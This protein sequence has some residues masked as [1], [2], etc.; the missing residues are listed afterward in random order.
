MK[1]YN[2]LGFFAVGALLMS[3]CAVNDPLMDKMEAGQVVPTVSWELASSVCKAGDNAAFLGKY[4]TTVEGLNID[5]A[6]VWGRVF[7][8]ENA[9]ASQK[10]IPSP[11]YSK[12]INNS[13]EIRGYHLLKEF[14]HK[15][16]YLIGKEYHMNESFPTS[17]T[18]SPVNWSSPAEWDE[19]MFNAYFPEG[20]RD[21]FKKQMVD[22]LTIDSTY[23]SSL[24]Q[25]YIDYGF[26]KEQLDSINSH[27]PDLE[28]I[29]YSSKAQTEKKNE[30]NVMA[31]NWLWF[32]ID[33][34]D[35]VGYYYII[36]DENGNEVEIQIPTKE[37]APESISENKIYEVYNSPHWVYS[38]FSDYTGGAI[39]AVRAEYMPLW[40]EL[41]ELITFEEWI[42]NKSEKSYSLEFARKYSMDVQYRV[43]DTEGG[44]G[45]DTD[46]KTIEL[47]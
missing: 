1:V 20:Y 6:E 16:E 37:D 15:E 40:K 27:Y 25:L 36:T 34:K 46:T 23:Y 35:V 45:K 33:T 30:G 2:K 18:L 10:L 44:E 26:T 24:R 39:T 4:Y 14:P 38:R 11:A 7:M 41:V 42:Y 8:S 32:S 21:E 31:R 47:N 5:H 28:P 12:P 9:S 3:S 13:A 29:P 17:S 22:Y 43:I 19:E